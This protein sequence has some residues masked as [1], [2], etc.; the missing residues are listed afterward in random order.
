MNIAKRVHDMTIHF[1]IVSDLENIRKSLAD[2]ER[3]C[4]TAMDTLEYRIESILEDMSGAMLCD[5]AEDDPL[6]VEEFLQ[7]TEQ[8]CQMAA[9]EL[10]KYSVSLDATFISLLFS[11]SPMFVDLVKLGSSSTR[12]GRIMFSCFQELL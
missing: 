2:L 3:L 11:L 1:D 10:T 4:R 8:T 12:H 7:T 5:L 6:T 9:V